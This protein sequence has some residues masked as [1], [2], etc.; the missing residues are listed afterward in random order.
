MVTFVLFLQY[1]LASVPAMVVL[2]KMIPEHR[3]GPFTGSCIGVVSVL[4]GIAFCQ[5]FGLDVTVSD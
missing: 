4:F 2:H 5:V 1:L 3:M